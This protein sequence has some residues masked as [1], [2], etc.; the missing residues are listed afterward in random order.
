[1]TNTTYK[2]NTHT[3]LRN[4]CERL[5]LNYDM[6]RQRIAEAIVV[7]SETNLYLVNH[8]DVKIDK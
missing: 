4:L 6:I 7:E 5:T 3:S 1:M 2:G 8:F